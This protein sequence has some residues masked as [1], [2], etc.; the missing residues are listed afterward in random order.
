MSRSP[1]RVVLWFRN[2]LRLA[3]N[4]LFHNSA[5]RGAKSVLPV[6]FFDPR[7]FSTNEWHENVKLPSNSP[8]FKCNN[9][10]AKFIIES[11]NNLQ[12]HLRVLNSD[13][14]V[15]SGY[16]ERILPQLCD[17]NTVV[18]TQKE[19]GPEEINVTQG[20]VE[21]GVQVLEFWGGSLLHADDLPK[22]CTTNLTGSFTGFRKTVE[23]DFKIRSLLPAPTKLP[24]TEDV[25]DIEG[26]VTQPM[27]L[28]RLGFPSVVLDSRRDLDF[29]GG[30]DA[31]LHRLQEFC[32]KG[33]A[34]YKKTRNGLEGANYS[35]HFSP[36]LA[37]GSL[38]AKQIYH[39][40]TD[41]ENK[42]GGQTVDTY[43]I[44]FELL[45]RDYFRFLLITHGNSLF[46]EYGP[47]NKACN[48]WQR[49]DEHFQKW[50][51]G[52]TGVP[53]V[54]AMMRQLKETGWMS[55]RGRQNVASFLL[56][57]L[58]L[59]WRLGAAHF[60]Q[61]L[62]DH[63]VASNYGN[64]AAAA[65]CFGGRP[66]RFNI[67]KQAH[68][69]DPKGTFTRKWVPELNKVPQRYLFEP[70]KMNHREQVTAGVVL[71]KDYPKNIT[72]VRGWDSNG[73]RKRKKAKRAHKGRNNRQFYTY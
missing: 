1:D 59:D 50:V 9:I 28:E 63:D 40:V 37:N 73:G 24:P 44:T 12:K 62:L 41:W 17:E 27:T 5:F 31:A 14:H 65:N 29:K 18:L 48:Q 56:F 4:V 2:D 70:W 30:A 64:W 47:R 52:M 71:G 72:A 16:P 68:D 51:N 55:N 61:T 46:R 22:K 53:F 35:S 43:W 67:V 32:A 6:F 38:S 57:E 20:V 36:W 10:R 25:R 39:A 8:I 26:Y 11:V 21:Q 33:L 49:N 7:H 19:H 45:W 23:N 58:A 13:L 15:F 34:T 3:D 69:Y 42:N 60:E 66:N 54:D